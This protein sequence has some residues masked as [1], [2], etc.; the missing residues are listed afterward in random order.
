[1]RIIDKNADYYDFW[2][3]VYR[4]DSITFDRTDSFTLTKELVCE[5]LWKAR[6]GRRDRREYYG[7]SF[8]LLQI[9]QSFWLLLVEDEKTLECGKPTDY[10]MEL[11][12]SWKDYDRP[13]CLIRLEIINFGHDVFW[14]MTNYSYRSGLRYDKTKI[15]ER[16][17]T[18]KDE[19]HH[20]N[21]TVTE[22]MNQYIM[23]MGDGKK[24]EKHIPLLKASGISACA[25]AHEVY[26]SF[27]EFFLLE[28][29]AS[30]R[31][32]SVGLTNNEKVENHG[33]DLTRSF[34]GKVG[35]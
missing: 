19:I 16:L 10:S 8:V 26:L 31:T 3:G 2:Q 21:Y 34:R 5:H 24:K 27:E 18:L 13:R 35:E 17:G 29:A 14:R 7:Y 20:G 12:S 23:S 15:L 1:M 32:E 6:P 22:S 30:E 4:D 9:C 28:K 25:D 11:L 33:F